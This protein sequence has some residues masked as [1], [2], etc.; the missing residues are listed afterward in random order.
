MNR[1]AKRGDYTG[2]GGK[3]NTRKV[4]RVYKSG[5]PGRRVH[6]LSVIYSIYD[7]HAERACT[8]FSTSLSLFGFS[9]PSPLYPP[10]PFPLIPT[11]LSAE[12]GRNLLPEP[13]TPRERV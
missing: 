9:S 8:R 3:R 7:I 11:V 1:G 5:W 10:P 2:G 12:P 13:Y 4:E 6:T